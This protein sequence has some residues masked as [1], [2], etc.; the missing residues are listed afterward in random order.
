[1]EG[2]A[3]AKQ[4][5]VYVNHGRKRMIDRVKVKQLREDDLSTYKIAEQMGISRMTV[6][7]ILNEEA[8]QDVPCKSL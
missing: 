4:R 2:I 3:K 7:R 1:L 5:G 6:H 8:A